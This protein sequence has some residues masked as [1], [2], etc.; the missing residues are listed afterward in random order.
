MFGNFTKRTVF[1]IMAGL[2]LWG[3][4]AVL[5]GN[6]DSG[7]K[8]AWSTNAGWINFNTEHDSVTVKADHLTGFAWAENVGWIKL[9]NGSS[10]PYTNTSS[11]NWG[12]NN[13]GSGNLS[14]FGWSKNVGWVNFKP[15]G[16]GQV[17]IDADGNF[18]GYAWGE[19]V[20]WIHFQNVS[21]AY[22]VATTWN[23]NPVVA[24]S[25]ATYSDAEN[26]GASNSVTLTR[27][28]F[29]DCVTEVEVSVTGGDATGETDYD[30][31]G[32]SMTVT[33]NTGENEKT[34][35][36]PVT[37]DAVDEEDETVIFSV[38]SVSNA[39]IGT[40]N[41][42]TLTITDDDTRGVTVTPTAGLVTTESGVTATFTVVLAS[43]P[44][45]EVT[46]GISSS[47][48]DEGT[49][50]P[51][52]LTF[53]PTGSPL[54]SDPQTVTV[55]GADDS[56]AAGDGNIVY[57]IVTAAATGGDYA[58]LDPDDVLVTNN[59]D[60]TPGITVTPTA[61]T[62]DESSGTEDFVIKLN[63]RPTGDTN[64]TV[65]LEV[66]EPCTLPVTSV[67]ITNAAWETGITVTVT[68]PD[69]SVVN[70]EGKRSCTVSTG[71]PTSTDSDYGN[72]G[73]DD[74]ADVT[75]TVQ[76]DE[77]AG[78]EISDISGNTTEAGGTAT[79]TVR[80][81]SEPSADVTVA[82]SSDDTTE[83]TVSPESLSFGSDDWDTTKTVT[84][85]GEDD[86]DTDGNV[87]Y[88]I[89]L[90]EAVS[91]DSDYHGTDPPDVSVTNTD[92]PSEYDPGDVNGDGEVDLKDAV[93]CLKVLAGISDTAEVRLATDVNDDG[94]IG[95]EELFFVLE[96]LAE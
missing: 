40:Q 91:D 87:A 54:W 86:G 66:T 43:Q 58:G 41:T 45:A 46:V 89:V 68:A 38:T 56:P 25:S 10:G 9:G 80:L 75:F 85:T 11:G 70:P 93:L 2:L 61:L 71:D 13:D 59:D 52:S 35:S 60:D 30:N 73:A 3:A 78:F 48:T 50:S 83:G 1:F 77:T 28:V 26:V 6:I 57:T 5:A 69:D 72:L 15:D 16:Q 37:D 36:V 42:A 21:P 65:P 18:D 44:T 92:D 94:R 95:F 23:P 4:E 47:N 33:F 49:V 79:F 8:Y 17:T 39:D 20:G 27:T 88:K 24:F 63:T 12:V 55:T 82:V 62:A 32:F 84:V 34:I 29:T 22:K 31:S 76:D 51:A 90:A 53:S 14:G 7:N 81:T 67:T 19:N 96:K 74:V 64:V